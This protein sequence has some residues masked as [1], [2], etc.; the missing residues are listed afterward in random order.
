MFLDTSVVSK[1]VLHYGTEGVA[2][3][4]I[5]IKRNH[6]VLQKEKRRRKS[7]YNNLPGEHWLLRKRGSH[8]PP[9]F[10]APKAALQVLCN[11]SHVTLRGCNMT[12]VALEGFVTKMLRLQLGRCCDG[13]N[14]GDIN[15]NIVYEM[16]QQIK[17]STR[18]FIS[19]HVKE[20]LW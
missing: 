9:Q 4:P 13:R 10:L 18:W 8:P 11:M 14:V 16:P 17:Q 12:H 2:L 20:A 5:S 19:Y 1:N 7:Y 3:S 6:Q 15:S